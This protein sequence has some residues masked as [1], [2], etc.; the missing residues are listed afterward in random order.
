LDVPGSVGPTITTG[1][2]LQIN[3]SFSH[4]AILQTF[5]HYRIEHPL[6]SGKRGRNVRLGNT[7]FRLSEIGWCKCYK[8]YT[9]IS[10][11]KMFTYT[12]RDI[13]LFT[14]K[15]GKKQ[16]DDYST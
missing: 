8:M 13:Q 15:K 16:N 12:M 1:S 7:Y 10:Y 9:F 6:T 11:R 14:F 3:T 5:Y 2:G 4:P